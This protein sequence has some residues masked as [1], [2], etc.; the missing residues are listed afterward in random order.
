MKS[1]IS[2]VLVL[3]VCVIVAG[4]VA[5]RLWLPGT[6]LA[7]TAEPAA[8]GA[9]PQVDARPVTGG[10][11]EPNKRP[12]PPVNIPTV[13]SRYATVRAEDFAKAVDQYAADGEPDP[14]STAA[15]NLNRLAVAVA[16]YRTAL[17]Y[18]GSA[19]VEEFHEVEVRLH[20]RMQGPVRADVLRDEAC[21]LRSIPKD[22]PPKK[23]PT[24]GTYVR[25]VEVATQLCEE[26]NEPVPVYLN[27]D[28][29]FGRAPRR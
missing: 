7:S 11:R 10:P 8:G 13:S 15:K 12:P 24:C 4:I 17:L 25:L 29:D 19:N 28:A 23:F 21:A 5:W 3:C 22:C 9:L 2:R 26:P 27:T 20:A 1:R 14:S 16:S 18:Y 6:E